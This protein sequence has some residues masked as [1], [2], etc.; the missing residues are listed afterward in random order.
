M[1]MNT[2]ILALISMALLFPS[3]A[4][5]IDP[6]T[7]A[8]GNLY[9]RLSD[10]FIPGAAEVFD[11]DAVLR[12]RNI[13]RSNNRLYRGPKKDADFFMEDRTAGTDVSWID[14]ETLVVL[15]GNSSRY[16]HG[17][18]GD[19]IE[20]TGFRVYRNKK[21][22]AEYELPRDRVF[23]TLRPLVAD[24]VPENPGVEIILTS[25][26]QSEGSRIDVYSQN[27]KFIGNSRPI[28]RGFRWLHI[29]AAAPL[30][31]GPEFSLVVVRTPHIGGILEIYTWIG[32][33]L[34]KAASYPDVSTHQIGSD[35]LNMAL[36]MDMDSAPGAEFLI[37]TS[38]FRS[39]AVLK[40]EN[41]ELQEVR[42]FDLP[43]RIST[44]FFFDSLGSPSV[45]V[46]LSNGMVV[47]LSE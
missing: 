43:D 18:L 31:G 47:K 39:L 35:N 26:S 25:S 45:W 27:G 4:F 14:A 44:N 22:S 8:D 23:E 3:W 33:Q 17:I 41:G 36:V 28:G 1:K 34:V 32:R 7:P 5:P 29:L 38:D 12:D 46:G 19:N 16:G 40:Y 11:D 13:Q 10:P 21:L 20:A 2:K 9:I 6:S 24:I 42:R 15:T 30:S 37:P